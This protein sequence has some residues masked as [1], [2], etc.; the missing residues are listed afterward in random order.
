MTESAPGRGRMTEPAPA[1]LISIPISP[2]PLVWGSRSTAT[3]PPEAVPS[4]VVVMDPRG[5]IALSCHRA[6][7]LFGYEPQELIGRSFDLLV[8]ACTGAARRRLLRAAPANAENGH[9]GSRQELRARRRDGSEFPARITF[10]TAE[11]EMGVMVTAVIVDASSQLGAAEHLHRATAQASAIAGLMET[12][13]EGETAGVLMRRAVEDVRKVLA[14]DRASVFD[15][16]ADGTSLRLRAGCGWPSELLGR[17]LARADPGE[18]RIELPELAARG[19]H[20]SAGCWIGVSERRFGVLAVHSD[21]AR[22]FSEEE[23]R[24]LEAAA[25]VLGHALARRELEDHL[26]H[27]ALHDSL[28]G[29]GNR[30]LFLDRLD[31]WLERASRQRERAALLFLDLDSFKL[32][33]D[34]LGHDAGDDLLRIVGRRLG[35]AMRLSTT[36]ARL[37]GDE[38]GVL[39]ESVRTGRDALA[40]AARIQHSLREPA[41]LGDRQVAVSASIGIALT[42]PRARSAELLVRNAD[43]AMYAAKRTGPGRVR[44]FDRQMHEAAMR[45]LRTERVL[46]E[47]IA[48]DEFMLVYQPIVCLDDES[49]V[50]FEALLRWRRNG[51]ILEPSHFIALAEESSLIVPLGLKALRRACRQAAEWQRRFGGHT[52][53]RVSV[54]LSARQLATPGLLGE[55][56]G[57]LSDSHLEAGRLSLEVAESTLTRASE[58]M[59]D[60]LN[61][62]RELGVHLVLDDFGKDD[63]ALAHLRRYPVTSIKID[64]SCVRAIDRLADRQAVVAAIT[65]TAAGLGIDVVAERVQTAREYDALRA[66]GCRF[67]QGYYFARPLTPED[68]TQALRGTV[69]IPADGSGGDEEP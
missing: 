4:A 21:T 68:A 19:V 12:A 7:Q 38:F 5:R 3:S 57:A 23:H 48:G 61:A 52:G 10:G 63:A 24:F 27:Q 17:V 62:L 47:A 37:G 32:I 18:A 67:G 29:L 64:E 65:A 33:N 2:Q 53:A 9:A 34:S 55:V 14:A 50:G 45:R 16:D 60:S 69:L 22:S 43:A 35:G 30:A 1:E 26:R 11:N 58:V 39:L 13:F 31:H 8:P 49:L 36:V 56:A 42:G 54:N 15:L 25:H 41:R 28:T 20:R 40:L 51:R 66:V 6:A 46:R 59:S 44:I